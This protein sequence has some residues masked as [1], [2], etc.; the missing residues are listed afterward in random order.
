MNRL[1]NGEAEIEDRTN[2]FFYGTSPNSGFLTQ[3]I[4]TNLRQLA[5]LLILLLKIV[6]LGTVA[7]E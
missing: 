6:R 4:F 3:N 2:E 7:K 5:S 1:L